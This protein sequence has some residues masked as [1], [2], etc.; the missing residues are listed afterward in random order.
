MLSA[1]ELESL[2]GSLLIEGV[3]VGVLSRV[4]QL[5]PELV[6]DAK[7][8]VRVQQYGTDDLQ[9]YTEQLQWD[10]LESARDTLANGSASEKT[11][12]MSSVL[13]KQIALNAR[14]TPEGQRRTQEALIDV[15][16]KMRT[17]EAPEAVEPSEFVVRAGGDT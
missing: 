12:L 8:K 10:A 17:D 15:F 11:K 2:V 1:D 14:R 6:K 4:F 5:D 16:A 9:E 3:P 13:G 7:S